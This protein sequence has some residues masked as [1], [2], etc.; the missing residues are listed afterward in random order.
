MSLGDRDRVFIVMQVVFSDVGEDV[1]LVHHVAWSL[2]DAVKA[3]P[4]ETI[5]TG[6]AEEHHWFYGG[7]S[8]QHDYLIWFTTDPQWTIREYEVR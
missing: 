3:L 4:R 8:W 2:E 5:L 7:V 1:G 6:K